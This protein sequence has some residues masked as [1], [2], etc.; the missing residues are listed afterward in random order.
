[1]SNVRYT[2]SSALQHAKV[3]FQ[4]LH[5]NVCSA[6]REEPECCPLPGPRMNRLRRNKDEWCLR[7]ARW[8]A[9]RGRRHLE[10]LPSARNQLLG[11]TSKNLLVAGRFPAC[12]CRREQAR[13]G[14]CCRTPS[15]AL[16]DKAPTNPLLFQLVVNRDLFCLRPT[17][18]LVA[19]GVSPYGFPNAVSPASR[20]STCDHQAL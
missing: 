9:H 2:L 1:M 11:Q 16:R 8:F 14:R 13:G 17:I 18:H 10:H 20:R 4:C 6:T 5:W 15:A 12:Q 19:P 7:P 3:R